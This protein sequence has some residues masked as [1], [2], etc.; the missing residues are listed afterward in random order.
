MIIRVPVMVLVA[1]V[2]VVNASC[3]S[4]RAGDA[5]AGTAGSSVAGTSTSE[6][7]EPSASEEP[8][9]APQAGWLELVC[10]GT[11]YAEAPPYGLT[12]TRPARV[13]REI[14]GESRF[15][16]EQDLNRRDGETFD[17]PAAMSAGDTPTVQVV[18]CAALGAERPSLSCQYSG[19]G[20]NTTIPVRG[21]NYVFTVREVKTGTVL[22]TVD[23]V[24]S[25]DCP[26]IIMGE[27][28]DHLIAAPTAQQYLD[29]MRPFVF[30]G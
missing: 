4:R 6:E 18:G 24:G 3:V 22:T 17:V 13:M 1:L 19:T 20:G 27:A 29:V 9:W 12:A 15:E 28:P 26:R 2:V 10:K 25:I 8:K 14:E 11:A 7:P 30:G 21:M 23:M 5:V 16:W